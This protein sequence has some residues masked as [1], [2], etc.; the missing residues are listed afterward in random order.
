MVPPAMSAPLRY[1]SRIEQG[2][3]FSPAPAHGAS[4]SSSAL[5]ADTVLDG[6]S[7]WVEGNLPPIDPVIN[8]I[9]GDMQSRSYAVLRQGGALIS[10]V[11]PRDR[12]VDAKHGVRAAFFLVDVTTE[13]LAQIAAILEA[14]TLT[15]SVG[16]ILPLAAGRVAHEMLARPIQCI[17]GIRWRM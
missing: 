17:A 7:R 13:W 8:L 14:G 10:T 6:D 4:T 5:G 1:S 16:A 3:G 11:A 12:S 2:C 9:G 15:T